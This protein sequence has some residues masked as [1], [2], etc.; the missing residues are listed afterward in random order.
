MRFLAQMCQTRTFNLYLVDR[1]RTSNDSAA[2]PRSPSLSLS[3]PCPLLS[4]IHTDIRPPHGDEGA[5]RLSRQQKT[6]KKIENK[7]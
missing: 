4:P 1:L 3:S 6:K 2:R 7:K 5:A